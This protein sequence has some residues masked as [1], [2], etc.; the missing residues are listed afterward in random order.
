MKWR[1]LRTYSVP[2]SF[3]ETG[4]HR[5]LTTLYLSRISGFVVSIEPSPIFYT[6]SQKFLSGQKNIE[7]LFGTSENSLNLSIEL[8]R[9]K[10]IESINFWLDGHFSSGKTFTGETISPILTEL[11]IIRQNLNFL[12]NVVVF[13]DDVR[14]FQNSETTGYPKLEQ[15]I[16]W[17]HMNKFAYSVSK[18]IAI[19]RRICNE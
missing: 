15:I 8:L 9:E 16:S 19:L 11:E 18:D 6:K 12:G 10:K 1:V 5:G 17:A 7:V 13:V 2:G 14:L 4:T 3:I